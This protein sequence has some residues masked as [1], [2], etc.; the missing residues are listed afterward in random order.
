MNNLF[1]VP[2]IHTHSSNVLSNKL[3]V[4]R[5][6][7]ENVYEEKQMCWKMHS[8]THTNTHR[9]STTF[10]HMETSHCVKALLMK[11]SLI[12]S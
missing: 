2:H 6:C 10:T 4:D 1:S 5:I 3:D 9:R 8:P 7:N 11:E 12:P